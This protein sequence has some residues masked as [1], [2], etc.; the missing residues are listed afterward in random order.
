MALSVPIL[1]HMLA[2]IQAAVITELSRFRKAAGPCIRYTDLQ[3]QTQHISDTDLQVP[4]YDLQVVPF[5]SCADTEG[6]SALNL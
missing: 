6:N 3:T 4:H 1:I 5:Y 2:L